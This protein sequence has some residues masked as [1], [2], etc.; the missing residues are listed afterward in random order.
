MPRSKIDLDT[1]QEDIITL[2]RSGQT[3]THIVQHLKE[4]H[5][6]SI[7]T[8]TIERRLAEWNVL[9]KRIKTEDS[10]QLRCRIAILFFECGF[11]DVDILYAL[12]QEGYSL[13][14]RA[15]VRIRKELGITRRISVHNREEADQELKKIVEAEFEK[16]PARGYGRGLLYY[17]FRSQGHVVSRFVRIQHSD[18]R[19]NILIFYFIEI[20]YLQWHVRWIPKA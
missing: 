4:V 5:D 18:F 6:I 14:H 3:S 2:Y 7:T 20:V 13:T 16:G 17:H 11:N 9:S 12:H 15:L 1:H 19:D 10:W 8:R